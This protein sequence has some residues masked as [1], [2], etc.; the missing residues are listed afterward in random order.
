MAGCLS[1]NRDEVPQ[2]LQAGPRKQAPD[3]LPRAGLT[4]R[5]EVASASDLQASARIHHGRAV[6][7]LADLA[8]VDF[9]EREGAGTRA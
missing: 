4:H 5:G 8:R 1:G 9:H 6:D 7:L 2:L 3:T